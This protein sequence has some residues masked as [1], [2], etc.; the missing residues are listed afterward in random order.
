[1]GVPCRPGA[2][3]RGVRVQLTVPHPAE[4]DKA[5]KGYVIIWLNEFVGG[6]RGVSLFQQGQGK[7]QKH[8]QAS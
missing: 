8:E 6:K 2:A 5:D 1:M 3:Q 7:I 4:K